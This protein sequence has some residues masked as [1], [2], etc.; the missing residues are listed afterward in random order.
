DLLRR[1]LEP[2]VVPVVPEG[3]DP[4]TI[5]LAVLALLKLAGA[6]ATFSKERLAAR[7]EDAPKWRGVTDLLEVVLDAQHTGSNNCA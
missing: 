7:L 6:S 3:L 1:W 5:P 4:A 2:A